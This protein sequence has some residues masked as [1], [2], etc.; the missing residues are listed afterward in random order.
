MPFELE[1]QRADQWCWAAVTLAVERYFSPASTLSQCQIAE[2]VLDGVNQCCSNPS[3]CNRPQ[4]L[5]DALDRFSR[6]KVILED[7]LPFDMV[8]RE[9]DARRP[10]CVRI[11]WPGGKTGHFVIIRG[12]RL[13][14]S[15]EQLVDVVD[16]LYDD[17]M[18]FYDDLKLAYQNAE[19]PGGGGQ[20]TAT[21]LV[22]D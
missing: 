21:F 18:I 3:G 4:K 1:Q 8:Q 5:Q 11:G 2:T 16:S 7:A 14:E 15:G 10:I 20:W 13:L 22:N 6:L 19:V 12:Y 9:I 17:A